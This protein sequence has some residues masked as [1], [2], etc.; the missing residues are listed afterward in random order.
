M[1]DA[2]LVR[3]FGGPAVISDA[4]MGDQGER[5]LVLTGDKHSRDFAVVK[6][7]RQ[8]GALVLIGDDRAL[9]AAHAEFHALVERASKQAQDAA[10]RA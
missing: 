8:C 5:S 9:L 2:W 10:Y 3:C 6:P 7:C 1:S 4:N